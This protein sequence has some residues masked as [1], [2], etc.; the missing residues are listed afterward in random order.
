MT[1]STMT[2]IHPG[3]PGKILTTT[4]HMKI[5]SKVG[6]S[7][8]NQDT[9]EITTG[10]NTNIKT[11]RCSTNTK[12]TSDFSI[13]SFKCHGFKSSYGSIM[14]LMKST[15][16]LFLSETW[17]K[18]CELCTVSNDMVKTGFWSNFKSSIDPET[19]L[20]GC[21]YGGVGIICK[22]VS[23]LTYIPLKT[24]N[25]RIL[26]F[27]IR[28]RERILVTIIGV[29]MP[30]FNG[31][32]SQTA[33]YYETLEDIQIFHQ[34]VTDCSILHDTV[35]IVS[36]HLP[37]HLLIRLQVEPKSKVPEDKLVRFNQFT[38]AL[39][40]QMKIR[41]DRLLNMLQNLQPLYLMWI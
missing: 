8:M 4:G 13:V 21:P 6:M 2:Q 17:L 32:A 34:S 18:P 7:G 41:V 11:G 20:E 37:M 10:H 39:T 5:K 14:E 28:S 33:E 3:D 16:M 29:Y 12:C 22:K 19:I 25:D 30:H 38:L 26:F 40:G 27:Q 1:K 31:S 9:A 24:E 36:D 15:D 23:G 35:D